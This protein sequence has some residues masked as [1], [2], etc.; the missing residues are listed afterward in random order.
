MSPD[1]GSD[2]YLN[3]GQLHEGQQALKYYTKALQIMNSDREAC[4]V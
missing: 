2:K 4:Q 1:I 3:M